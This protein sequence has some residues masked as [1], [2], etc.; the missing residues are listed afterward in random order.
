METSNISSGTSSGQESPIDWSLCILCQ[1]TSEEK[2][3]CPSKSTRPNYGSGYETL[4]RN[5]LSFHEMGALPADIDLTQLDDGN[6]IEHTFKFHQASWHKS[7]FNRFSNLK[8]QRAQKRKSDQSSRVY[9][10]SPVKTRSIQRQVSPSEQSENLCFFCD[11]PGDALHRACTFD[12]DKHVRWCATELQDTKLL[13]KLA[14]GDLPAIDAQYHTNC[15]LALYNR[16]RKKQTESKSDSKQ[17]TCESVAL[18]ELV[19]YIEDSRNSDDLS[20]TPTIFKLTDLVKLYSSRLNQLGAYIPSRINSTRLKERLLNQVPDLQAYSEGRDVMLTF[21]SDIGIALRNA[22]NQSYDSEIMHL[23]KAAKFLRQDMLTKQQHFS[24][25]FQSDCN[26]QAVPD[27]LLAF[28]NML[29]EGP[30]IKQKS[31]HVDNSAAVA[32]SELLI[33]NAVNR[34]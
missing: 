9:Q 3:V 23:A 29:L 7:C 26:Q 25:S 30:N 5:L 1:K 15:L 6:G 18:A 13:A 8:L 21:S 12:L 34:K 14:A 19:S 2:L 27:S 20:Q 16:A 28:M 10:S 31:D 17:A 24:G 33:F 11:T 32:L 22:C 4:A